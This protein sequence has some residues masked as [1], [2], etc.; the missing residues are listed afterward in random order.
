MLGILKQRGKSIFLGTTI[1]DEG[2]NS[3]YHWLADPPA[4]VRDTFNINR[5]KFL[6]A[7]GGRSVKAGQKPRVKNEPAERA[8]FQKTAQNMKN[9]KA[10]GATLGVGG[11][12]GGGGNL[13]GWSFHL[14]MEQMVESGAFTPMETI[15]AATKTNAEWLG[16]KDLGTIATGKSADFVV[17]DASP[18]DQI[19]NTRM[20]NK[21]YMR[22][23]EVNR[24]AMKAKWAKWWETATD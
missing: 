13:I 10:T 15:V 12:G 2:T 24:P 11:D 22:G 1:G 5:I 4:L 14:E 6:Q 18:L 19:T 3:N 16:L 8:N 20:I 23:N 7:S 17:L 21:V 9:L